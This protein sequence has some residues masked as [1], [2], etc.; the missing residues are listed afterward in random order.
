MGK[1][2]LNDY[3]KITGNNMKEIY[4]LSDGAAKKH[5]KKK[6]AGIPKTITVHKPEDGEAA[7]EA[8]AESACKV[9]AKRFAVD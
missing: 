3:D 6:L 9:L 5:S 8:L 4:S 2:T 1:I 7:A